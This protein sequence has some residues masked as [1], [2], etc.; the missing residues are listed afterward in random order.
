MATFKLTIDGQTVEAESGMTVL[1]AARNA[2]IFIPS[3]CAHDELSPYGACRLCVVEIDN[4]RGT[5]TA[6]TTPAA[7]GMVV[8]TNTE[9]LAS[10]RRSTIELM[11]SAHPS[12]CF[13]CESRHDCEAERA[14]PTKAG[15]ATRCGTCSN[16]PV[17]ELRTVVD[18]NFS[19]ELNLPIT[20]SLD[21]IENNDPFIDRN[22]NLCVLCG[23]CFRVCE[24]I[25]S[26]PAIAIANRG[27]RA[28][29]SS[30]FGKSWS[31]EECLFCG[32]CIDECP[33]GTL[34]D[35][36]GKWFGAP[37]SSAETI[38]GLC[39]K[40]CRVSLKIKDGKVIGAKAVSLKRE[41]SLCAVGRFVLPQIL[42][43]KLRLTTGQAMLDGEQVPTHGEALVQRAVEILSQSDGKILMIGS[44]GEHYETRKGM[45]ALAKRFGAK[46]IELA[47]SAT[48]ADFPKDVSE[49]IIA[50]KY[51]TIF[52]IGD[53]LPAELAEG[54][55]LI[56]ADFARSELQ[57]SAELVLPI[58]FSAETAGSFAGANG[59]KLTRQAVVKCVG[60]VRPMCGY[61]ADICKLA[62][63]NPREIDF[64]LEKLPEDFISPSE[65]KSQIPAFL[66][67]HYLTDF[68]PDLA[69]LGL[70]TSPAAEKRAK[71][72]AESGYEIVSKKMVA[73]NFHEIE[74]LAPDMAK[75]AKVGQFAILMANTDSERS[76]FTLVDW[77]AD[78]GTVT[79]IVE[80]LGRSSAE[81]GALRA[82][83][84]L[85]V[86]SGPLGTPLDLEQFK[87]GSSVLLCGGCYG[88]GA[89]YPLAREL[90]ARGIKT[91][92]VIEASSA[93]M[94]Y[95]KEKLARVAGELVVYTRDGS[96]GKK[97]GCAKFIEENGANFD[98]LIAIG[99]VF[100]MNQ[101]AKVASTNES[102]TRLC[103]LNPIMVDG[104]G[105]CGACRVSVAGETKFACVD[106]PYFDLSKV[107]FKELAARRNA[108]KLL[109]IEAMPRHIGGKCHS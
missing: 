103:S 24:K 26:K 13:S 88:I 50:G 64:E 46:M 35:R 109:E 84:K 70:P 27:S 56:V 19:R 83:D 87:V 73:P 90:K 14:T 43:S 78:K 67:G 92:C 72:K 60:D 82:G 3:L 71:R 21:K 69:M 17:C 32:A 105:M 41:D 4:V 53:C 31:S 79:F 86:A 63:A 48:K 25:H 106:G 108:Y 100:M 89:I 61:I 54:I 58:A 29:I 57:R 47:S 55:R 20:Y 65:D 49:E 99:C 68:A 94:L 96:E 2:G 10:Q 95:N 39:P 62:D 38:C 81:I 85:A 59:E 66:F 16:R 28:R 37:D 5:P 36:W 42:S 15:S 91:T 33:T 30:E 80:E 77:D 98:S 40:H 22:H 45:R 11:M 51:S 7:E 1:Q 8:R 12:P 76:P 44:L 93:Y 75:H 6:C 34:T 9:Q 52:C 107:D 97:G 102:Q 104:T 18:G 101:C 74:I 23:R